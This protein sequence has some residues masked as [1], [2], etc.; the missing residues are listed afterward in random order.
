MKKLMALLLSIALLCTCTA[1]LA[2]AAEATADEFQFAHYQFR[3]LTGD[4]ITAL[5]LTDNKTGEVQQ[6]L[7]EG[8]SLGKD[9]I[10][11]LSFSVEGSE[12]KEELEH[13]Y[14]LSFTTAGG[15]TAEFKT[16]SFEDVLIDLLAAD[17]VTGATPIKFNLKM[18]QVGNYKIINKTDKV[19]ESITITEN[20]DTNNNST[21]APMLDP[22]MFCFVDFSVDPE[23]E[24]SHALTIRFNFADG[25]ECSFGTLSIEEA[26]LTL[27]PDTITGAT[28]FTFGP[29]DAE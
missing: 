6:L 13:R 22:D 16:L 4:D 18:F 11:Y 15:Y 24:A 23:S 17:A 7:S 14:T 20:A 3:N 5:S 9:E 21:V 12:P 8:T 1:V 26:S 28:P 10:L 2:E 27:T 25:T 19:I 29:I